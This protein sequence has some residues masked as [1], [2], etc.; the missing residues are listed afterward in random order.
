ILD[1][2]EVGRRHG[3]CTLYAL[4]T[5][6]FAPDIYRDTLAIRPVFSS[7]VKVSGCG[8]LPVNSSIIRVKIA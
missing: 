3:A 1:V 2:G 8:A 7:A 4:H 6:S 5:T